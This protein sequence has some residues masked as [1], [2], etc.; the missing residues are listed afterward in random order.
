MRARTQ[1][2]LSVYERGIAQALE[3]RHGYTAAD[4]RALVV[5]YIAVVRKLGGYEQPAHYA[6]LL[7]RARRMKQL[8]SQWLAHIQEVE[9]GELIDSGIEAED[10]QFLQTR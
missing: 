7:N 5:D 8:P 9:K 6:E 2:R 4:A 3:E 1:V 10:G